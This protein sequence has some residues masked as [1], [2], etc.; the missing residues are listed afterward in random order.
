VFDSKTRVAAL[1]IISF[2]AFNLLLSISVDVNVSDKKSVW[3]RTMM[4][5]DELK[6]TEDYSNRDIHTR[7][8]SYESRMALRKFDESDL[9]KKIVGSGYG[10]KIDMGLY[11]LLGEYEFRY[12]PI[13][14][15]GYF[16]VLIKAGV[17]GLFMLIL[18]YFRVYYYG[19]KFGSDNSG[20]KLIISRLMI[21][22]SIVFS[23]T[24]L[25]VAGPYN[26]GMMDSL[27]VMLGML[28]Y[29]MDKNVGN[30]ETEK[31]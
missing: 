12:I 30:V 20:D 21:S 27:L 24:T 23:V 9:M 13:L 6:L 16:F 8:R 19:C 28:I 18:F 3:A 5:L 14:H 10:S 17:L 2:F 26:K 4:S 25:S 29:F 7:W 1:I 31:S 11:M 15:N 22:L